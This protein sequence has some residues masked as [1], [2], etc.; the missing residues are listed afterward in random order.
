MKTLLIL[1]LVSTLWSQ[2]PFHLDKIGTGLLFG[3]DFNGTELDP[4]IWVTWPHEGTGISVYVHNGELEVSGTP[5]D[6]ATYHVGVRSDGTD[7][8]WETRDAVM[9]GRI[10]IPSWPDTCNPL[11]NGNIM[12]NKIEFHFCNRAPDRNTSII[13]R[14]NCNSNNDSVPRINKLYYVNP[15]AVRTGLGLFISYNDQKASHF[16]DD[17]GQ[18]IPVGGETGDIL[19]NGKRM[20]LKAYSLKEGLY[21]DYRY[22]WACVYLQPLDY[23][24][25]LVLNGSISAARP[26]R[27][28]LAYDDTL[29]E[30]TGTDTLRLFLAENRLYPTEAVLSLYDNN[31]QLFAADTIAYDGQLNGLFPGDTFLVNPGSGSMNV[32]LKHDNSLLNIFPNPIHSAALFRLS[33]HLSNKNIQIKIFDLNGR[34]WDINRQRNMPSNIYIARIITKDR[35]QQKRIVLLK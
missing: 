19:P 7:L 2:S 9:A 14:P 4:D 10:R 5:T 1:F 20:E 25:V 21:L 32:N 12:D 31:S 26:F 33:K 30:A 34:L 24:V 15:E 28:E 23:P 35:I 18:V 8:M 17:N 22:D 27:A 16:V 3:D 11:V 13:L 29:A 6:Q